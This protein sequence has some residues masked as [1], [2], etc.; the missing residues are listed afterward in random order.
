MNTYNYIGCA[1]ANADSV[2]MDIND[3][4]DKTVGCAIARA[5]MMIFCLAPILMILVTMTMTVVV[6][7]HVTQLD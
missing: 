4:D 5:A 1:I 2:L 6:Q 7:K 3:S